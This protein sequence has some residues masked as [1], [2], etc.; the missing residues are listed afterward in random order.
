MVMRRSGGFRGGFDRQQV[1]NEFFPSTFDVPE[2]K[3]PAP[4]ADPAPATPKPFIAPVAPVAPVVLP[5]RTTDGLFSD[6]IPK[7]TTPTID[8]WDDSKTVNPKPSPRDPW[9]DSSTP[10]PFTA[11]RST[12]TNTPTPTAPTASEGLLLPEYNGRLQAPS[13]AGITTYDTPEESIDA[14]AN[15]LSGQQGQSRALVAAPGRLGRS[16]MV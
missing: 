15:W 7:P 13:L 11:P 10:K 1:E 5:T 2:Y 16:K 4:Y 6:L 12:P 3:A 9:D 14:Y 8:P